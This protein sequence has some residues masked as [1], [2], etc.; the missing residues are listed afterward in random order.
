MTDIIITRTFAAPR[1]LVYDAWLTPE[2]FAAWFGGTASEVPLES[3]SM[4]VTVGG[5]WKATMFAGPDRYEINW[6]GHFLV[7]DRPSQLALTLTDADEE[8]EPITVDFVEVE[9][10]T[11]MGTEMTFRQAATHLDADNA[12]Q[13]RAGWGTFFDALAA[14]V[15]S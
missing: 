3:V 12:A 8:G 2:H 15:E 4:D 9:V 10:G 7:L 5:A 1:E 13:A 6:K 11:E 14:I